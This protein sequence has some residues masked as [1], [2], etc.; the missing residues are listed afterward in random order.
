MFV[1][2]TS[3]NGATWTFGRPSAPTRVRG[4]AAEFCRVGA[5]RL[6]PDDSNIFATG[7]FAA[8]T[9]QLLRNYAL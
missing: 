8:Q 6:S 7:P 4:T 1:E 2:L 3:P 5:R 9:L